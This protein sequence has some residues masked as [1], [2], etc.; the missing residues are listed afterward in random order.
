MKFNIFGFFE[1]HYKSITAIITIGVT[2]GCFAY[3]YNLEDKSDTFI[4]ATA[5][6]AF[7]F[8]AGLYLSYMSN[9]ISGK[10]YQR[11][12]EYIMLTRLDEIF[13]TSCM[14][15]LDSYRD[16]LFAIISFQAFSGRNKE[17]YTKDEKKKAITNTIPADFLLKEQPQLDN[18][19]LSYRGYSIREIGFKFEPEL[20]KVED[21]FTH[22]YSEIKETIQNTVND[23]ISENE[24]KLNISGEFF[25]LD[26]LST[27]YEDWCNEHV[28]EESIDKKEDLIKYIF[29]A[30]ASK[31]SEFNKLDE[32]K[33]KLVKYYTKCNMKIQSNLKRMNDTYGYRMEY[34]VKTKDDIIDKM[35]II[36]ERIDEVEKIIEY[37]ASDTMD[38]TK[39][40][41]R[42]VSG[43]YSELQDMQENLITE[44]QVDVEMLEED[45]GME[46]DAKEKFKEMIKIG[47]K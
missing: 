19:E 15:S 16:V 24:I 7:L 33:K 32:R 9:S 46:I 29:M 17:Q 35:D 44:I 13:S 12:N 34:I 18:I 28:S 45:L 39:E 36:L 4:I 11:R 26:L 6:A 14:T 43:L 20:Q 41:N 5:Y 47:R 42:N 25:E 8:I 27:N 40:C 3:Y 38:A 21:A 23:Y 31:E 37:Y 2:I 30:I 1:K 22:K 10:L